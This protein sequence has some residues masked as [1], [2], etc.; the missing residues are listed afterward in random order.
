MADNNSNANRSAARPTGT[1]DLAAESRRRI[2]DIVSQVDAEMDRRARDAAR[3]RYWGWLPTI[4]QS[5]IVEE[6]VPPYRYPGD[7]TPGHR[8]PPFRVPMEQAFA[9]HV[10]CTRREVWRGRELTDEV[11]VLREKSDRLER[12]NERLEERNNRLEAQMEALRLQM[13]QLLTEHGQVVDVVQ[14]HDVRITENRTDIT[15]TQAMVQA[16]DAMLN[17][18]AA[19]FIEEPPQ[20]DGPEFE[21][22]DLEEEDLDEDPNEDPEE[23]D[24]DGDA[25]SDIS[26][27]RK[28]EP[29]HQQ[30]HQP[31]QQQRSAPARAFTATQPDD[32]GKGVY[33]GKYPLCNRCS[34][35]HL[36]QC[37]R[38]RC[39]KCGRHG[40]MAKD[41]RSRFPTNNSNPNHNQNNNQNTSRGCYECGKPG[42][43]RRD[44]PQL[45]KAGGGAAKGRAFVIGSGEAKDDPNIVTG[46]FPLNNVYASILFDT[47]ADRSFIS[48]EFSKLLDITPTPLDYKYTVELADGKLI[49][50]QHIFRGC[51]MVLADHELEID[52][53][54]VTLGSFDVVVG[55][56]WLSAN[57]AEI[58]C[59]EKIVRVTLQN[60]EQISIQG[61][62]R[63]VPLNIMSCMKAN[64]YLQKGYTAILALIAEQPKKERKIEDIAV[65]R[66]FPEI[67]PEDLP[68]LPPKR[69]VEFQIDLTPGAAPIAKAPYRLAPTEMQELSN[70]LQELLDKGFIRPS[71]SPWGAP[72][73][74][75]KKKDG[76]FR[77]CIDYRELNKVTIKNRYPLPRIDDLF[78]QLQGSSYYSKIDLRSGYHQLRIQE[79]DIPKTAFRTRYGHY[80]F[81]V[82]PFGLTNAPA[83]FM[84]LMNRVY[85]PYLDKF[86]IVF[87]DDIL[88][89]SKNQEEHAEHLRLV[90]EL[91]K[92][93]QLYAKFSKCDFWIREVQFLGHVVN[94][95]GIHVDPA[96]I[97]AIKN[98]E[99]PKTPTEVRQFLGL[100]GY[101]RRFIEGFSKIA[102]SLTSLTHKDKKFDWGDKQET[103]F[104]LLKQKLCTAPILSL[105]EGC[106]DFVVYCDASKQGLGCVL[107]QR[108]KVIAYASRQLKVHEKNYTTHDLELGA[109][110]FALKIWRHYLYG[111]KCTI[112]TDHKSLQH[113]FDQKEL[114]MRQRRWVEL[115][116]DY[117][118]AIKYHP[119]KANVV[120]DALSRK[121]TTKRVRALQLTIHSELPNQIRNAQQEALKAENLTLEAMRGM[122]KQLKAKGDGAYYLMNRIWIPR[123]GGLREVVMDEAHKS[124]Y[125]IHPG[126]DKM[127]HDLKTT[128]WWPNMKAEI[129]TYVGKCLT[130]S[131]VKV[132]YQKPSG[133]LQQPELPMWKWEQI[134]MDFITKL[135]KTAS[136]CDTIWVIVDRLTKSAHFLP[137]KETDKLDKLTRVYLKEVVTR[138]GVPISII[139]DRDSRFTSH[140]WKSLHKALGTRL[141]MS[142]AYHPQTDGQSER[143][144]QTLEDM[145]RACVID[146]G[147]SWESHL[148]LV[149]FS[150]NN[151]YHT[152][153]QAAPFE[154][155]YGRKCRSPICWAEVGDS[156]LT[157]PELVHETTEKIVQIRK[158]MAAARDR[159]KSYADKRRKPLE[160]QVGDRVLL[161]VSPWKGVIRFG[162]RGKLNPRYIGPF[163]I[164]KRIGPVPYELNLPVE[165]SS[166]HNVFHISNLKKC[167][168]DETLVIPLEEIQ[169][170]E[171][172]NF[173]EEP[174]E[175][176]DRE[177]KKLKLSKIPIVN[178]RWNSR[179]GPEFTW[180]RE[181][182]MKQKYPHLF[183]EQTNANNTRDLSRYATAHKDTVTIRD[184]WRGKFE[185]GTSSRYARGTLEAVALR[186]ETQFAESLFNQD[187]II[188][189]QPSLSF[190]IPRHSNS[191]PT[192]A[193]HHFHQLEA[194]VE[195][196]EAQEH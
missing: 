4:L 61:E 34:Y 112:F 156:Q 50:T 130:C 109:V 66:D 33:Q 117:D 25:A 13:S 101:Y 192:P 163:E 166:V 10:A 174:V 5:W 132:E 143:T 26:H 31:Q 81:L 20:E 173:V 181:D 12:Q 71:F 105:P 191:S 147:S 162:K 92:K 36:G 149:E 11:R 145:L 140:F 39:L 108:E 139:S 67:F 135:P 2:D 72:V 133:L 9:A 54:P 93:E 18:W 56:D 42:H 89:Y 141:D 40:H 28:W 55:M 57:Q 1:D 86:V 87:I 148:P 152:S 124:R 98:W 64:K 150:Y 186:E 23:D 90:L 168:S 84:D 136:G 21:A 52:L 102:Q 94:E 37:E 27:K 22:E 178:V 46:T 83:V 35:H 154:A 19:Q 184:R 48:S 14:E 99:A 17:A 103:A 74:F 91:L 126:S 38:Y 106:E 6:R 189:S 110:V 137:I 144:I 164:T 65:V 97:E 171:Q 100:A 107:M 43:M 77:M 76:S 113:I 155:L 193:N 121:E 53:M 24:D 15:E 95:R 170:D 120:A 104:N 177:T 167:L 161:K 30:S 129:A 180:E 187:V 169:I 116:G 49:E 182:Q 79:N 114:N 165:L 3:A 160:F 96:K 8:L 131:K 183:A 138:H 195:E 80:E 153:I 115:I 190:P 16:S 75:V 159:Q 123:Y 128:Y 179:R 157:G 62:R 125:S 175:I 70:Q 111:T 151:S 188:T 44:C 134:S 176:M 82:M 7:T 122:D 78:D 127:Y 47:G 29:S 32:K 73:L 172:L 69:Q 119:G 63:G 158:R 194:I 68:G 85:K 45:K 41:C 59:N 185:R 118:C 51:V 142:T 88:I 60:G 58:V 146:F 196:I